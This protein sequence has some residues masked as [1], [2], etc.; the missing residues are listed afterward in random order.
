MVGKLGDLVKN[1]RQLVMSDG[2][3]NSLESRPTQ[4][5]RDTHPFLHAPQMQLRVSV[6]SFQRLRCIFPTTE[7]ITEDST[8]SKSLKVLDSSKILVYS[9]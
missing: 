2:K 8:G 7:D 3:P 4:V 5:R 6:H 1:C 9:Y